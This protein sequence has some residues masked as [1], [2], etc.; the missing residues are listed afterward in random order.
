MQGG[1][2][3]GKSASAADLL[4]KWRSE[5]KDQE[6]LIG[7]NTFKQLHDSTLRAIERRLNQYGFEEDKHFKYREGKKYLDF[8]GMTCYLRTLDNIDKAIAGMEVEKILLDEYAF[9]GRPGQTAEYTH[10][11]LIQRL[12]GQN[13]YLQ[14]V[15]LTS[16]N[17]INFLHNTWIVNKTDEH[18]FIKCKTQDNIFLPDGYYEAMLA[19]YGGPDSPLSKQELFGEFINVNQGRTYYAFDVNANVHELNHDPYGSFLIG[20]DFNIGRMS[21]VICQIVND[22]VWVVDEVFLTE[23]NSDTFRMRDELI[24]RGYKGCSIYPDHTGK[25]RKTSGKSDFKILRDYFNIETTRNPYVKDRVNNVNLM[26][27]ENRIKISKKCVNLINDLE[28]VVWK[29][30]DLDQD[31]DKYLTHLSDSLGYLCW[32]LYPLTEKNIN[33]SNYH[34]AV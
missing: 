14:F 19:Q 17:G 27:M 30:N 13:S 16:P 3:S 34:R 31:S 11:K 24:K 21:A 12:R 18:K 29:G 33:R 8:M 5:C 1:V 25:N 28:K 26:L 10:D 4:V 6:V 7:A 9:V 2:G 20:M 15:A 22:E 32:A 23:T